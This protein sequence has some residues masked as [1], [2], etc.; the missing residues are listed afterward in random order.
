MVAQMLSYARIFVI[1]PMQTKIDASQQTHKPS[2]G[3]GD[4]PLMQLLARIK[5]SFL[6][7]GSALQNPVIKQS[8]QSEN[9]CVN[10]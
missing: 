1:E 6:E 9:R 2:Q 5:F 7:E 10:K 8:L 3:Q 4:L